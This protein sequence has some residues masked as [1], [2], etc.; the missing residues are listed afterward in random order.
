MKFHSDYYE[1]GF[2]RNEIEKFLLSYDI[3]LTIESPTLHVQDKKY[4]DWAEELKAKEIFTVWQ[5]ACILIGVNP[6]SPDNE[7][8]QHDERFN[9][10]KDLIDEAAT[11]NKLKYELRNGKYGGNSFLHGDLRIWAASIQREWCIPPLESI[12]SLSLLDIKPQTDDVVL[13]RLQQSESENAGL[14]ADKVKLREN[15]EKAQETIILQKQ[16]L[17][18]ATNRLTASIR[19]HAIFKTEF[20]GLK[21]DA[22]EGK[23]KSTLQ[24]ILGG[25]VM[26]GY[27]KDIHASRIAGI[28]E[29]VSDLALSGVSIK[30]DT[31]SKHLKAA[32]ELIPKPK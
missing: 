18:D 24:K 3:H 6:Y 27:G 19:E 29:I 23:T 5:A 8:L 31:L 11:L 4:P 28:S 25:V 30:E 17:T 32:A 1:Y 12:E 14:Q 21:A 13:E 26:K 9:V 16:Q 7:Y 10:A 15:L 22:L 2:S 20:D